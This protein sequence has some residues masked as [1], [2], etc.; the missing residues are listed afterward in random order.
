MS[1]S[2]SRRSFLQMS[3]LSTLGVALAACVPAPAAQ[4][5]AAAGDEAG[6]A[7]TA[8]TPI[9]FHARIGTQGDYFTQMAEQF[10]GEQSEVAVTV[11]AFPGDGYYQKISTMIAG[12]T[13]G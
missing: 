12:G 8:A 10:N 7:T 11:E 5:E 1:H 6:A 9:R 3:A 13:I 2:L 4:P